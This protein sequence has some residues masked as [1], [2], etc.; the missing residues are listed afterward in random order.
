MSVL[1]EAWKFGEALQRTLCFHRIPCF[2]VLGHLRNSTP[3]LP[4]IRRASPPTQNQQTK[5]WG[6]ISQLLI[7]LRADGQWVILTAWPLPRRGGHSIPKQIEMLVSTNPSYRSINKLSSIYSTKIS[8]ISRDGRKV[9]P[10]LNC[11]WTISSYSALFHQ[12]S[13]ISEG[14]GK[15]CGSPL[16][17]GKT[18]FKISLSLP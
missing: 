10:E 7:S 5:A 1:P 16:N 9:F 11:S 15:K 4:Y 18:N 13:C 6:T 17:T 8:I 12:A 3:Q 14:R 2:N